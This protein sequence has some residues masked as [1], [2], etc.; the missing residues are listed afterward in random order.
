MGRARL[1]GVLAVLSLLV[2]AASLAS[3]LSPQETRARL[4]RLSQAISGVRGWRSDRASFWFDPDYAAF[5]DEVKR[6]TPESSTVAI[7][8]PQA[9]DLYLYQAMYRLAPRRVVEE[10]WK[11]EA[12]FIATYRS[13]AARGPGGAAITGG[14]LWTR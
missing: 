3:T 1:R 14:M 11:N 12:D 9:P 8:V 5:L 2:L 6:R 13:E 4:D 7:L 10:R